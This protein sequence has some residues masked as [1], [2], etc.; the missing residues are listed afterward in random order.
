M[1]TFYPKVCFAFTSDE[2]TIRVWGDTDQV[3]LAAGP[4]PSLCELKVPRHEF[5]KFADDYDRNGSLELYWSSPTVPDVVLQGWSVDHVEDSLVGTLP[6]S[7]VPQVCEK[8]IALADRRWEFLDWRGGTVF[9]GIVNKATPDG[10][11][12]TNDL[13]DLV[14]PLGATYQD[15]IFY[16]KNKLQYATGLAP[17]ASDRVPDALS[18]QDSMP[19]D[20]AWD[21]IHVF[22]EIQRLLAETEAT[23]LVRTDGTY[24]IKMLGAGDAPALP[25]EKL[26]P[27][28]ANFSRNRTSETIVI[29]SAPARGI[30]SRTFGGIGLAEGEKAYW[31]YVAYDTDGTLKPLEELS[32]LGPAGGRVAKAEEYV[33]TD[34][35]GLPADIAASARSSLFTILRLVGTQAYPR[36]RFLPIL[37]R[38]A[39]VMTDGGGVRR[40]EAVI[41]TATAPVRQNGV[42][43]NMEH[44]R[45]SDFTV[46]CVNG[47]ITSSYLLG[48]VDPDGVTD[49]PKHFK[50][51]ASG[52]VA[53]TITSENRDNAGT[54][55]SWQDYYCRG[56]LRNALGEVEGLG[57]ERLAAALGP[58]GQNVRVISMPELVSWVVAG[59]GGGANTYLNGEA[60][61]DRAW[62]VA[63]RVLR[64]IDAAKVYRYIGFH[65]VSPNGNIPSVKW[66]LK[67]GLTEFT[68]KGYYV[69]RSRFA[70]VRSA[71][72][73]AK[74]TAG[75][76]RTL[77]DLPRQQAL[78]GRD[79]AR[80]PATPP[81]RSVYSTDAPSAAW[82]KVV[83]CY[84]GGVVLSGRER[85][86]LI[87]YVTAHPLDPAT[88]VADESVTIKI[89]FPDSDWVVDG[90]Q[91]DERQL[92]IG[93]YFIPAGTRLVYWPG[94]VTSN[95]GM[96]CDGIDLGLCREPPIL[97]SS[98]AAYPQDRELVTLVGV[99]G[100]NGGLVLDYVKRVFDP[101]G[102]IVEEKAFSSAGITGSVNVNGTDYG[103]TITVTNPTP[104]P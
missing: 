33:R 103:V 41:V 74:K 63:E 53:I 90:G 9:A 4:A 47:L 59:T 48:K 10:T 13:A 86:R 100:V 84:E 30:I 104:T 56:F 92:A 29:T 40:P 31:E 49:Y 25:P 66:L 95:D 58:N 79:V 24:E 19:R 62:G 44:V 72:A 87:D 52:D 39:N 71:F 65:D 91:N 3:E 12:V 23:W 50:A 28:D 73:D 17:L 64:E 46:D 11:G 21:G 94:R 60:L 2:D 89:A 16:L 18:M 77:A 27:S 5:V 32:W 83:A 101:Q 78:G 61:D 8:T 80:Q 37:A 85:G 14:H 88:G 22:S 1:A 76:N 102:R 99:H 81:G 20:L 43:S 69:S 36:E 42:F 54:S 75:A 7:D 55:T 68:H 93:A 51:W 82:A 38:G 96:I 26:L 6:G 35:A 70:D 15:L 45:L 97:F 67:Q 34:F 57:E 98:N